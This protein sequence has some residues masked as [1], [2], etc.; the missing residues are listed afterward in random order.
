MAELTANV[1]RNP[2]R[3]RR[4]VKEAKVLL[5]EAR[6]MLK[7]HAARVGPEPAGAVRTAIVELESALEGGDHL[8]VRPALVRLEGRIDDHLAFG[9]KSAIREYAESIGVAILIA[10]FLRSFVVEA[11]KIPSGSMIPTLQVGDHIFVNK[12]IYG[13][14]IPGTDLKFFQVRKPQRGEVVV[15]RFPNPYHLAS[16]EDKDFIKR[17]VA[18]EGDT[19]EVRDRVLY[20]N[21]TAVPHERVQANGCAYEDVLDEGAGVF[22]EKRCEAYDERLGGHHY[23]TYFDPTGGAARD[24]P[25][26]TVPPHSV[27]CMGDNRD[28][29]N[30]SRFWGPVSDELIKGRAMFIWWSRG[31]D[32][33][34]W[35][36]MFSNVR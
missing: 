5:Y 17:I 24:W 35:D 6:R 18:V 22:V 36:R 23:T 21:G 2:R 14:R 31:R 27:F 30:D 25:P 3:E 26:R 11:F 20:V 7:K 13:L 1:E 10:L 8:A 34:R 32:G 9:R 16:E 29:S 12:Y 19:V 15:F 28:N 4:T 33:I